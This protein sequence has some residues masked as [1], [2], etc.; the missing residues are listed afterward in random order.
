MKRCRIKP[1]VEKKIQRKKNSRISENLAAPPP[2]MISIGLEK[3][4][5]ICI[6][7]DEDGGN[8]G[9]GSDATATSNCIFSFLRLSLCRCFRFV[10]IRHNSSLLAFFFSSRA[11]INGIANISS[12]LHR[13]L[14]KIFSARSIFD[15]NAESYARMC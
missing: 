11:R 2:S 15:S 1:K 4:M 5:C 8:G 10:L 6:L 9:D 14:T 3:N 7:H 12:R 13:K